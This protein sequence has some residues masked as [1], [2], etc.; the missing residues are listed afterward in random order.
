M[1]NLPKRR[2]FQ[3]G[4]HTFLIAVK[5]ILILFAVYVSQ[6]EFQ[7]CSSDDSLDHMKSNFSATIICRDDPSSIPVNRQPE[8]FFV[9]R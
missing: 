6:V 5:L 8:V 1:V 7:I 9:D 2:F 3:F 4:L